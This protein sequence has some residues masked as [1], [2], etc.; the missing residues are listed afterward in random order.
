MKNILQNFYIFSKLSLSISLLIILIIVGY[1]FYRSYSSLSLKNIEEANNSK[2]LINSIDINSSRIEKLEALL[3]E[4]NLKLNKISET[5][6]KNNEK[7][8]TNLF[9]KE[10]QNEFK[11]IKTELKKL[12]NDFQQTETAKDHSTQTKQNNINVKNTAQLI[13]LKFESGQD[14]SSELELLSELIGSKF[15]HI[16]EKLYLINNNR[17]I[18]IDFLY[19]NFKKETDIYISTNLIQSNKLIETMLPYINIEPSKTKKLSDKRLIVINNISTQ[20]ENKKYLEAIASI[21]LLDENY[22]F[23]NSTIE[24]LTIAV[25]FT[26]TLEDII[27]HD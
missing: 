1:L 24:Q 11:K 16:I 25:D 27:I 4:S 15:I 2:D 19:S 26:K 12:Q 3:N 20:L 18:G 7:E 9:L 17:F 22:K 10:I 13:K 5:L 14:Y 6:E 8:N 21:K 23:F